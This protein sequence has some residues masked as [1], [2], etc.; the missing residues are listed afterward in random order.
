MSDRRDTNCTEGMDERCGIMALKRGDEIKP[1]TPKLVQRR[2]G[3]RKSTW[4][5]LRTIAQWHNF[6]HDHAARLSSSEIARLLLDAHV[7]LLNALHKPSREEITACILDTIPIEVKC[8]DDEPKALRS[9]VYME[10]RTL[11]M[12]ENVVSHHRIHHP[13]EAALSVSEITGLILDGHAQAIL[14]L[15]EPTR[16]KIE[17]Y[18]GWIRSGQRI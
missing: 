16:A 18:A 10:R 11:D 5:R 15:K 4:E 14:M 9:S 13:K 2:F 3:C 7:E 1:K 6:R 17:G 8:L 12:L